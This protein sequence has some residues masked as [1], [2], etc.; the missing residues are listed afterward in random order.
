MGYVK[1][2]VHMLIPN[3]TLGFDVYLQIADKKLLYIKRDDTIEE[4]RIKKL[5]DKNVIEVYL[6]EKDYPLYLGYLDS[7]FKNALQDNKTSVEQK[8]VLV[9]A[10]SKEVVSRMFEEPNKENYKRTEKAAIDQVE[11]LLKSP[12]S[13]EALLMMSRHDHSLYQHSVNV[14]TISIGLGLHLK[15]P[16][17]V[18]EHLGIGALLHD[19]GRMH[20]GKI[21]SPSE[22]EYN[23]H[24]RFGA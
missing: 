2:P 6:T 9:T 19:I 23:Q 24:P 10:Q 20:E 11:L 8:V 3:V 5:V 16:E 17:K 22:A 4:S 14:A 12:Q 7:K 13:L 21:I 15:A 1:I 18:C